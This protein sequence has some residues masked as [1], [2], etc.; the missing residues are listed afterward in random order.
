[1]TLREKFIQEV[2]SWVGTPYVI[3]G[4]TKG[5]LGGTNCAI[6]VLD[7]LEKSLPIGD[8]MHFIWSLPHREVVKLKMDIVVPALKN[9]CDEISK[10]ELRPGDIQVLKRCKIPVQPVINVAPDIFIFATPTRGVVRDSLPFKY[11]N[12]ISHTLR[13]RMFD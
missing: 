10:D 3:E 5:N 9:F 13:P 1:M 6:W 4:C 8:V 7:S 11:Q 2:E 12:L